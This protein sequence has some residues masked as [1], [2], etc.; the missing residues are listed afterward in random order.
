MRIPRTVGILVAVVAGCILAGVLY[1]FMFVRIKDENT[2]IAMLQVTI[3]TAA[4][5]QAKLESAKEV[6]ALTL[7]EREEL[8]RYILSNDAVVDFI[9]DLEGLKT[10]TGAVV[11]VVT[12]NVA[13]SGTASS[14]TEGLTLTLNAEGSWNQVMHLL[15]IIETLPYSVRITNVGLHKLGGGGK[16]K[17][18]Y[19]QETITFVV[20][21]FR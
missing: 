19:W 4:D 9:E 10:I 15:S 16:G 12:V 20:Q 17:A 7:R 5:Q 6:F 14:T 3:D 8:D 18:V 1:A 11:Q 13:A 2:E 21:K